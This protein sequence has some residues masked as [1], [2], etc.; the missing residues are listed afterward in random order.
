MVM[1]IN[2]KWLAALVTFY[3]LLDP[4]E[5][6]LSQANQSADQGLV[7][8]WTFNQSSEKGPDSYTGNFEE[9]TGVHGM[10]LKF[11]GFTTYIEKELS[12]VQIT[13]GPLTVEA[14]IA[15]AS[16]P[17]DWSPIADCSRDELTGFFFGIN[18]EGH[19]GLKIAAGNS[20]HEIE[21]KSALPLA[22]WAHVCAVFIPG[23]KVVDLYQWGRGGIW[24]DQGKLYPIAHMGKLM[25]G[26]NAQPKTWVER[27]LTT[28]DSYFFLDGILDEVKI[29]DR[30]RSGGGNPKGICIR[31]KS[32][33]TGA[34]RKEG[35]SNRTGG[36][37]RFWRLLYQA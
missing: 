37:R 5:F 24:E 31:F 25:I 12:N 1:K 35:F 29:Y 11:D 4:G 32:A 8:N 28:E 36:F 22:K 2:V 26:R 17:W 20:W 19:V 30:A 15:L 27:Q 6:V 18:N 3:L 34:E 13:D 7:F 21:T 23:E 14:W 10:A 16:Y 33:G 9:V